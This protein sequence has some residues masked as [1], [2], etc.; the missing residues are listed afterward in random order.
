MIVLS[1]DQPLQ[2]SVSEM[3]VKIGI[4]VLWGEIL[5]IFVLKSYQIN[6]KN[7]GLAQMSTSIL[8]KYSI[9][10]KK[11]AARGLFFEK[12]TGTAGFLIGPIFLGSI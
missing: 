4:S 5:K 3:T 12:M 10:S 2:N 9:L 8:Q 7:R 1:Y 6:Y 11:S